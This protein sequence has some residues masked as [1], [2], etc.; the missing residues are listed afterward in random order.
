MSSKIQVR[1]DELCKVRNASM[2]PRI[3]KVCKRGYCTAVVKKINKAS[4]RVA[5]IHPNYEESVK[6]Y[7]VQLDALWKLKA[8]Q[9]KALERKI[10]NNAGKRDAPKLPT[11]TEISVCTDTVLG[12]QTS[13]LVSLSSSCTA[14]YFAHDSVVNFTGDAIVNAA[15]EGCL[16]GG[17]VDG[18]INRR[19]GP[20]LLNAR[21]E[22]PFVDTW[23]RCETGD[24]KIT[25]AGALPCAKVIHAVGPMF[26]HG[27]EHEA[28]LALLESAYK[29]SIERAVE[30]GL[31]SVAFC[32]LSGGIFRGSCPL[33][34]VIKAGMK[35]I[36]EHASVSGLET[37]V[38]C[39]FTPD[40]KEIF[41]QAIKELLMDAM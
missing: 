14:F 28:D 22:L 24:A 34:T 3:H 33:L 8:K 12:L 41:P 9:R 30:N 11:I 32:I 10:K 31:K 13:M 6:T 39:A 16:G 35:A 4:V 1:I 26:G 21:Q 27:D 25:V 20:E 5:L 40:E 2:W 15:N 18:E 19:G 17:G 36:A 23:K 37:V 29:S 7:L 38:F